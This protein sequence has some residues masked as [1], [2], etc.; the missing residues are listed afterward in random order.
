M[1]KKDNIQE[2]FKVLDQKMTEKG[3]NE[4]LVI[5]G[6]GALL[7][8]GIGNE[9]RY[10]EDVDVVKPSFD[11]EMWLIS[12]ETGEQFGM[13]MGWLNTAGLIFSRNFPE[14]W[15]TRT[16]EV[17]N[18]KSLKVKSLGRSD[19]ISTKFQAL[20]DRA[21]ATDR[22]DMKALKPTDK[23]LKVARDWVISLKPEVKDLADDLLKIFKS[24][25]RG[26]G[27]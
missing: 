2:V 13:K 17:F 3:R 19:L 4:E 27:R 21:K 18:G 7:V 26:L 11:N 10:T 16:V 23:E 1:I 9:T 12:A 20:C 25:G 24:K 8:Q 14:G 5:F 15:E 6:S 22:E